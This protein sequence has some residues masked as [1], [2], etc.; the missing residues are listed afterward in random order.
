M[1]S[2]LNGGRN[3]EALKAA[4]KNAPLRTKHQPTK[5]RATQLVMRVLCATKAVD[6]D[7]IIQSLDRD[8]LDLLM[9]YVYKGFEFPSEG[10]SAQLLTW[11][12]KLFNVGG[13]GCIV[14]VLTDRK[15][16]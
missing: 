4:L 6:I 10:S 15:R 13:L 2:L 12:E 14:R 8:Q 11:H 7:K 5:D 1:Q 3:L 9:K 16:L